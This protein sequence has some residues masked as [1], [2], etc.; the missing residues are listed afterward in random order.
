MTDSTGSHVFNRRFAFS[1]LVVSFLLFTFVIAGCQ[2]ASRFA[3]R[4]RAVPSFEAVYS[5]PNRLLVNNIL[6]TAFSQ[7]GNRYRYGGNSPETGFDCSGFVS[8]VYKQYGVNLPRSSRDMLG[9]GTPIEKADLRPGDLVFFNYGYSHVGIYTGND[10][11]IHSPSTGKR[12]QESDINGA[13]RKN[14]YVGARRVIDNQGVTNISASLKAEWVKQS[15]HQTTLALNDQAATRHTGAKANYSRPKNTAS[16]GKNANSAARTKNGGGKNAKTHKVAN[17]DTLYDLS[18]RYGVS[19]SDLVAYNHMPNANK[20]K[21]GQTIKIPQKSSKQAS[22]KSKSAA[23][24]SGKSSGSKTKKPAP[25][26][27]SKKK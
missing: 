24:G 4:P 14:H 11:Y 18:K 2:K 16:K 10:K 20:L 9:V 12:I 19:T 27:S 3:A 15:R 6:K 1:L 5:E 23:K 8:W 25:K 17:G 7:F 22:A 13:G 21:P 26:A